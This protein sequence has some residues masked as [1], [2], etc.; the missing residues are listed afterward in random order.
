MK[1]G[2]AKP[3]HMPVWFQAKEEGYQSP[4]QHTLKALMQGQRQSR[5]FTSRLPT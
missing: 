4:I 1:A 5:P 3:S 2:F